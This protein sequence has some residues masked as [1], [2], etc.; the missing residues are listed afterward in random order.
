MIA[1][2]AGVT[3]PIARAVMS[4]V[5]ADLRE[6][7]VHGDLPVTDS[8]GRWWLLR[9]CCDGNCRLRHVSRHIWAVYADERVK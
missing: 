2:A 4:T 5:E 7:A 3:G 9:F 8:V 6:T 1:R